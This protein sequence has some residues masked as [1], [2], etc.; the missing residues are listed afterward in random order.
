MY[1]GERF[2]AWTHL[3]GAVLA[4]IGAIWLLVVAGMQ[5]D[6]WKI[7]SFSVYGASKAGLHGFAET[8]LVGEQGALGER[9]IERKQRRIHLMRIEIDLR[10]DQR[11]S[12]LLNAIRGAAASQLMGEVLGVVGGNHG[13]G[14]CWYFCNCP[15]THWIV[16]DDPEG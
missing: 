1:H 6:P 12:Q 13:L 11:A 16:Q 10:I 14:R 4:C 9:R 2:N 15:A 5:G 3:V 7:V 8:H